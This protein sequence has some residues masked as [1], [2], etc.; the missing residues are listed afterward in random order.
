MMQTIR[1]LLIEDDED[2]FV[3]VRDVLRDTRTARFEIQ[4]ESTVESGLAALRR[5]GHDVC[6]VDY[7]LGGKNGLEL[8]ARARDAGSQVPVVLLTGHAT[9]EMD[10]AAMRAGASD[11][12]DKSQVSQPIFERTIRYAFERGRAMQ[13]LRASERRFRALIEQSPE[14]ILVHR[15][16]EVVYANPAAVRYL[17]YARGDDLRG[18]PVLDLV[19]EGDRHAFEEHLATVTAEKDSSSLSVSAAAAAASSPPPPLVMRFKRADG[20]TASAEVV[21]LAFAFDGQ[22]AVVAIARDLGAQLEARARLALADRLSSVGTLAAGVAHEI[23]NPLASVLSNVGYSA[24]ELRRL[25]DGAADS[26]VTEAITA[27][28][29]NVIEALADARDGADRVR[30]IVADLR[31]FSRAEAGRRD[32]LDVAQLLARCIGMSEREIRMRARLVTSYG[33]V[34]Q[35][36]ANEARLSQVFLNLLGNAVQAVPEGA[37]AVNEIA[38]RTYERDG[39][40]VV[41]VSDSGA[42]M[43]PEVRARVFDPFFTTKPVGVGTGLGL[44]VC[45]SVVTALGGE[46]EVESEQGKGS[47]FRVVLPSIAA[48]QPQTAPAVVKPPTTPAERRGKVLVVDDEPMIASSLRRALGREH[49][50]ACATSG[51]DALEM[52]EQGQSYDVILCDLAMPGISGIDL[53]E[54]IEKR[55]PQLKPRLVFVTGGAFTARARD[56]L[57]RVENPCV[58]KPLD[59]ARVRALVRDVVRQVGGG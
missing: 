8:L 25:I 11:Y 5:G 54:A 44:F 35:V 15:A 46:I 10:V 22:P 9:T 51:E 12:L 40:A 48:Q 39:R 45:H 3:L 57:A 58:E 18:K 16:S 41:E 32:T 21:E 49:D 4:W 42:G 28:L 59:T 6:L 13:A 27:K 50:V 2:D 30:A 52:L 26:G 37:P 55:F 36:D 17:G 34:P 1:V 14:V 33:P 31:T 7:E 38:V 20:G 43:A 56:F 24:D 47:K 23:N 53:Y 19:E 29:R